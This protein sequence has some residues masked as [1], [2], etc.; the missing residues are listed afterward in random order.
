VNG[1]DL[2]ANALVR[3]DRDGEAKTIELDGSLVGQPF[4]TGALEIT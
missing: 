3:Y 4:S 1:A 2:I